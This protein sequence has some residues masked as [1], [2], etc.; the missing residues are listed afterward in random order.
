MYSDSKVK[1]PEYYNGKFFIYEWMRNWILAVTMDENGDLVKMEPFLPNMELVRPMDMDFGADGAMY[2]LE[3]GQDWFKKNEKARLVRVEYSE[4]NHS[5]QAVATVLKNEGA[6]PF[7][8][9]FSAKESIDRDKDEKLSYA[10]SFTGSK[11]QSTE[12]EPSYTFNEP[13]TYEVVLVVT[14]SKGARS[15]TKTEVKVG[16]AIEAEIS[17]AEMG[18]QRAAENFL[19]GKEQI[20]NSDCRACHAVDKT[21]I[22]PSYLEIA[23]RYKDD[24]KAH[25]ML[26]E[27]ILL[28]GRGNWGDLANGSTSTAF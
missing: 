28:G 25:G 8:A 2:I 14:D 4:E 18:H 22:G 20:E 21:V 3:Y 16:E 15:I 7:T 24:D 13:G 11:I 19:A 9:S 6:A 17:G 27:K 12:V 23:N 10:W 26:V 5:P 1:F